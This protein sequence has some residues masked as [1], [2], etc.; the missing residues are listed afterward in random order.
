MP[1]IRSKLLDTRVRISP[2]AFEALDE[3]CVSTGL[4]KFEVGSTAVLEHISAQVISRKTKA[5]KNQS[6]L[7]ERLTAMQ[8]E[9]ADVR[10]QLGLH[11]AFEQDEHFRQ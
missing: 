10:V 4:T 3:F 11:S 6:N 8:E 9:I 5:K 7:I 1:R 2:Q